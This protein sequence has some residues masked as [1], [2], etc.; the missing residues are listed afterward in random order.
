[1]NLCNC[2][3]N[4]NQLIILARCVADHRCL[5]KL[6]LHKGNDITDIGAEA[7]LEV[8]KEQVISL[9]ENT[10]DHRL[11][12]IF[13]D[14]LSLER[15]LNPDL[16]A[17]LDETVNILAFG[18][19]Q[20]LTRSIYKREG[21]VDS[22]IYTHILFKKI[23]AACTQEK[24]PN[25]SRIE[26]LMQNCLQ[27][28]WPPSNYHDLEKLIMFALH[29]SG[30]LKLTYS[31]F[32]TNLEGFIEAVN[33]LDDSVSQS[34]IT[35]DLTPVQETAQAVQP[36]S[37]QAKRASAA[38]LLFAFEPIVEETEPG[39][40]S[41]SPFSFQG[42]GGDQG[43][44]GDGSSQKGKGN[45]FS[46]SN[47]STPTAFGNQSRPGSANMSKSSN[48]KKT[49]GS[50][51]S[52]SRLAVSTTPKSGRGSPKS[53]GRGGNGSMLSP[54]RPKSPVRIASE[55]SPVRKFA[56][57]DM[58]GSNLDSFRIPETIP[59]K[60]Y[61][62]IRKLN[63]SD[64]R[65]LKI[66]FSVFKEVTN[67]LDLTLAR[68]AIMKISGILPKGLQR[69]DMSYNRL[70]EVKC[71]ACCLSLRDLYLSNNEIDSL[72]GLPSSSLER[73]DLTNNA[74]SGK[75]TLRILAVCDK[76][77]SVSMDGNPITRSF[78]SWKSR[79]SSYLP[80][81]VE[82]DGER[83]IGRKKFVPLDENFALLG[84]EVFRVSMSEQDR[85]DRR[86]SLVFDE[87]LEKHR[88]KAIAKQNAEAEALEK[89]AKPVKKLSAEEVSRVSRR[90]SVSKMSFQHGLEQSS[91]SPPPAPETS[92]IKKS[93]PK[94]EVKTNKKNDEWI[95]ECKSRIDRAIPVADSL[96]R[97]L[98]VGNLITEDAATNFESLVE[99]LKFLG[100]TSFL[101]RGESFQN[102]SLK[103]DLSALDSVLRDAVF[104]LKSDRTDLYAASI[105]LKS[106]IASSVGD[107]VR[108]LIEGQRDQ[109][110]N[111]NYGSS[112][113]ENIIPPPVMLSTEEV[114][115]QVSKLKERAQRRVSTSFNLDFMAQLDFESEIKPDIEETLVPGVDNFLAQGSNY[116]GERESCVATLAVSNPNEME[117]AQ[118]AFI[119]PAPAPAHV[120][121][122]SEGT[123]EFLST[124]NEQDVSLSVS[125]QEIEPI[126]S[127]VNAQAETER[128]DHFS[129]DE[130]TQDSSVANEGEVYVAETS[131]DLV[132]KE[133]GKKKDETPV[134]A[135][136]E[137]EIAPSDSASQLASP[138][139]STKDRLK[140]KVAKIKREKEEETL[141]F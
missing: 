17:A 141:N 112:I 76:L 85:N 1:M 107:K 96:F 31:K 73:I 22:G 118:P 98:E 26:E 33:E 24:E 140:V 83:R 136:D 100:D 97:S 93:S 15:N 110:A 54:Q 37:G 63:L 77:A 34:V 135:G 62:L 114:Y 133:H 9:V 131:V 104:N 80:R 11:G 47:N 42:N 39:I 108:L 79:L 111:E 61:S 4:D 139:M 137:Q 5:K 120:P 102:P 45:E 70:Q 57:I 127:D 119:V 65:I 46:R 82:I 12:M 92:W 3:I 74:L 18:N 117:Y 103:Y 87:K 44:T 35:Q 7:L 28:V 32:Q 66:D 138:S 40:T 75:F 88:L 105:N 55:D 10:V 90:L 84:T 128:D 38:S 122:P 101:S 71:L 113:E 106:I 134:I 59:Q 81:L 49:P 20:Q 123:K 125:S 48:S 129:R 13:L 53:P 116:H 6:E 115:S 91:T 94:P 58:T 64:N 43:S 69:L 14:E 68:N 99:G 41:S 89:I 16:I 109:G 27:K 67:L 8:L 50:N 95:D 124:K 121:L 130:F 30:K 52:R 36:G 25:N 86:K 60:N 72:D 126:I 19:Y 132:E 2:L 23:Y 78:S 56:S 51:A 29:E 21:G